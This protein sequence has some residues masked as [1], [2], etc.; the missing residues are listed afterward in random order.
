MIMMIYDV[1]SQFPEASVHPH[2]ALRC[3]LWAV[4]VVLIRGSLANRF[5]VALVLP[6]CLVLHYVQFVKFLSKA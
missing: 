6:L 4:P 3:H 2:I 5:L 1:F